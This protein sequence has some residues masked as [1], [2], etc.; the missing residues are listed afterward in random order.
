MV[1]QA[2]SGGRSG[3]LL[4]WTNQVYRKR[5][6]EFRV[7]FVVSM[8]LLRCQNCKTEFYV[9]NRTI[10]FCNTCNHYV[11]TYWTK[12]KSGK[13]LNGEERKAIQVEFLQSFDPLDHSN[14]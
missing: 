9:A 4:L 13:R 6:S 14:C 12:S 3:R 2:H 8:R 1:A 7:G 10:P 5:L 11:T